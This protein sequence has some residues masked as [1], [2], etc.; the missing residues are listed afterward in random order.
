MCSS[1]LMGP[2]S[3]ADPTSAS[4]LAKDMSVLGVRWVGDQDGDGVSELVCQFHRSSDSTSG[5]IVLKM[6]NLGK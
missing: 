5:F 3:G 4:W 2:V 6:T 1:D